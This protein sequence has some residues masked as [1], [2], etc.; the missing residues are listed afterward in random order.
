MKYRKDFVTNSSSSSFVCDVCGYET[1][2]WD[3]GLS[4]AG[5]YEC[6]N[7]HTFCENEALKMDRKEMIQSILEMEFYD[8][9]DKDTNESIYVHKDKDEV[10]AMSDDDLMDII[11]DDRYEVPSCICPICQLTAL[12]DRDIIK[13]MFKKHNTNNDKTL[14]EIKQKF[15]NYNV[16]KKYLTEE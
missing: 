1:S 4:D 8:H 6:V 5:M 9:Y 7:G 3:M 11:C 2:G 10:N 16:F 14:K 12:T 15:G 13:Y